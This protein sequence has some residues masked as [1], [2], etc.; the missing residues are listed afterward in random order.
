[1][2]APKGWPSVGQLR[3]I[4]S[5]FIV[6]IPANSDGARLRQ[7]GREGRRLRRRASSRAS[8]AASGYLNVNA[9]PY[10]AQS[11]R[12]MI[13]GPQKRMRPSTR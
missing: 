3:P 13:Q 12:A 8:A 4:F 2:D 9:R 5:Q 10:N 11:V 7:L 1:M 6:G